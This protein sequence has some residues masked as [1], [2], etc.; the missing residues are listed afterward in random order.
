LV[1]LFHILLYFQHTSTLRGHLNLMPSGHFGVLIFFVHT[2]LVLLFSLERQDSRAPGAPLF[3]PFLIRRIF[4]IY[5]LSIL[6]VVLVELFRIPVGHLRDSQFFFVNLHATG[7]LS[8]IFLLQ[9]LTHTESAI[10]PLWS[11]PYEMRVYLL[12]PLIY[13]LA[14]KWRSPLP[15]ALLWI[16]A[17]IAARA[18]TTLKNLVSRTGSF[19]PLASWLAPSPT[20]LHLFV[21]SICPRR[22]GPSLSL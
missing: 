17:V 15:V 14:K 20:K 2:S 22:F 12:L 7:I 1:V 21:V 11:L 16:L 13:L 5:P 8:N 3:T 9:D 10:A 4:R 19:L 6:V 18:L